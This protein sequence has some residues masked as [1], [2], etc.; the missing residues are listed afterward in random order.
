MLSFNK[1]TKIAKIKGGKFND[2]VIHLYDPDEKEND[3]NNENNEDEELLKIINNKKNNEIDFMALLKTLKKK[4]NQK[5]ENLGKEFTIDDGDL[6]PLP[7]KDKCER[8]YIFGP[9]GSGKSTYCGKYMNEMKIMNPEK[10]IVIFSEVIQDKALDFLNPMRIALDEELITHPIQPDE[11]ENDIL[12]FDDID[13]LDNDKVQKAILKLR[14]KILSRGRHKNI[15]VITTSHEPMLGPKTRKQISE[16]SYITFF[17]KSGQSAAIKAFLEKYAG[18]GKEQVN[19][20]LN[21]P[22]RWCTLHKKYPLYIIYS[23]GVY[24]L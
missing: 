4:G 6:I 19:R 16:S 10:R 17:P 11:I 15:T 24:L 9:S 1:G 13:T 21:L 22:S 12:L 5:I 18:M 14:D 7:N 3:P 20:V 8:D 2:K 23:K